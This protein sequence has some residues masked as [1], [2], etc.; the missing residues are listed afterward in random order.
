MRPAILTPDQVLEAAKRLPRVPLA[1]LPTPLDEVPRFAKAIGAG[2][3][4]IKRDDC[5]GLLLG[6]NKARHTE[7]VLGDALKKGADMLVWGAGEQSNNCRQTAAGCAKL[8]L[9]CRLYLSRGRTGG[10]VQG[11]L[12]LDYLV[13]AKVELVDEKIGI[14]LD[15]L[16]ARKA[17][18]FRAAGRKPYVW[19]R[20]HVKPV[21][22]VS[23]AEC[24]AEITAQLR[25]QGLEPGAIYVCSAGSTGA[26]TALGNA[27]LG[28]KGPVRSISPMAWPWDVPEDL[29]RIANSAAELMG[30][31]HRMKAGDMD[32]C[33]D[34]IGDG[35]GIPTKASEEATR[36]LAQKEGILLDPTYTSKA[37]AALI[38]DARAG[39][40]DRSR[41]AVF[42]HTGGLPLVFSFA[43]EMLAAAKG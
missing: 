39:R 35:Y 33:E 10:K 17:A 11:N 21:A 32:Y 7:H 37:M 20:H 14:E 5:T 8:G 31:P 2:R 3:V 30:L 16:L 26:G 41:P 28:L 12:L 42:I 4:F 36:L 9:E 29:A 22:A 27:I 13:G 25:A 38:A 18:E 23:Y 43:D 6:G 24:V 34:Y 1:H 40:L 19:D 15:E